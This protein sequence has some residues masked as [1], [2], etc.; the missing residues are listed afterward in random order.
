MV[1]SEL[2]LNLLV[3]SPCP[4]KAPLEQRVSAKIRELCAGEEEILSYQIVSNAVKQESVFLNLA[5][6]EEIDDLPDIMMAPG[7]SRFFYP[8]FIENFRNKG[9]FASVCGPP[10]ALYGELGIPDPEG[11]YDIV[12]FNPLIFLVD[13]TKHPDLPVPRRWS[14]L[15]N[16]R[17][18][19]LISYR[20][21]NE[22]SFCEGVLLT[23]YREFGYDGICELARTVK[24]RLHPA[25]MAKLA[26]SGRPEAPAVS[27]I[28]AFFANIAG[29]SK[30]VSVVWPEDGAAVNPLVML[31][32]KDVPER[33]RALA[34]YLAG[35][36][37]GKIAHDTGYYSV[38]PGLDTPEF[39]GGSYKWIGWDFL[40]SHDVSGLLAELNGLMCACADGGAA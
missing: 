38:Y 21:H 6:A 37:V 25:E 30:N 5:Q 16:P 18:D 24:N 4:L 35:S 9:F 29:R 2:G 36:E 31:V 32:K 14:D 20:G 8:D 22:R 27:V 33:V 7:I 34:R 13:R 17:Y 3:L 1:T 28:P 11:F 23:I 40:L 19:G 12:A 39:M 15:L 26:G 10:S